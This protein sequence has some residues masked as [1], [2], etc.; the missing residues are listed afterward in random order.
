MPRVS[1]TKT[2]SQFPHPTDG[3]AVTMTAA[4]TANDHQFV[5]TGTEIVLA[6]NT[7]ASPHTVTITSFADELGRVGHIT[8]D[9]IAAGAIHV[10]GPFHQSEGWRQSDGM[11]YLEADHAE[12]KFGIVIVKS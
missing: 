8:A 1:L 2:T 4:D 3:V 6:H 11:L 12:I 7:G 9:S 10:Y 5:L